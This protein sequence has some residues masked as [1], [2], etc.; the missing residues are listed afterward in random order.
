MA[1]T[2]D[3]ASTDQ[4][5]ATVTITHE[6][7]HVPDHIRRGGRRRR[8]TGAPPALPRKLGLSGSFWVG[9]M[10]WV[11][12]VTVLLLNVGPVL[13]FSNRIETWWLVLLAGFLVS[14]EVFREIRV[15]FTSLRLARPRHERAIAG[16]DHEATAE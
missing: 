2:L 3:A 7:H 6:A 15:P 16:R 4:T 5:D 8:P 14:I 11:A 9:M 12:I 10:A 1:D 13:R